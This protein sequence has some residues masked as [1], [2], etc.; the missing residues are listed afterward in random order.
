MGVG[1]I[2]NPKKVDY[3]NEEW[4]HVAQVGCS[5]GFLWT[6]VFTFVPT[7]LTAAPIETCNAVR[8]LFTISYEWVYLRIR[9]QTVK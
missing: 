3:E 8:T 7:L 5:G 4:I 6:Q 9:S 1:E 2:T